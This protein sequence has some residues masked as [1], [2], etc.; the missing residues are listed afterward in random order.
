M[1]ARAGATAAAE[2]AIAAARVRASIDEPLRRLD[3]R[4][5][6]RF[7]VR[8]RLIATRLVEGR[9]SHGGGGEIRTHGR[10]APSRVFKTRALNRSATPPLG[11]TGNRRA[12]A[13]IV[14]AASH[15]PAHLQRAASAPTS[16]LQS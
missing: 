9:R 6:G 4:A 11:A 7:A 1:S 10:V 14:D 3:D 2:R 12:A 5:R 15:K 16:E 8:S 13:S